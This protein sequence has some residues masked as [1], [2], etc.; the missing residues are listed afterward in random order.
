MITKQTINAIS[1]V[2]QWPA[3]TIT[4]KDGLRTT[5]R[6][7]EM[8][9]YEI[10][11]EIEEDLGVRVEDDMVKKLNTVEDLCDHVNKLYYLRGNT[12]H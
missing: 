2:L 4:L 10:L 3:E 5:L 6:C 12:L 9:V 7:G 11:A 1:R 8:D